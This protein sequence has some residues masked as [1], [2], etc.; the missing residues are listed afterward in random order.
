M[1]QPGRET[2]TPNQ[3]HDKHLNIFEVIF[4]KLSFWVGRTQAPYQAHDKHL[5]LFEE[6]FY[7]VL[8]DQVEEPRHINKHIASIYHKMASKKDK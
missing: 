8:F 5:N 1:T 2:R 7:D 6:I 4:L 3:T